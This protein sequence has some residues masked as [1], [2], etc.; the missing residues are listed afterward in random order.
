M[1]QSIRSPAGRPGVLDRFLAVA[2]DGV[3][4]K[5][6]R[7]LATLAVARG[8]HDEER[9]RATEL[10]TR[11]RDWTAAALGRLGTS[12]VLLPPGR[13]RSG[14]DAFQLLQALEP[15]EEELDALAADPP[16]R[17]L[18]GAAKA[19]A[20]T[21]TQIGPLPAG[22]LGSVRAPGIGTHLVEEISPTEEHLLEVGRHAGQAL[23]A[24]ASA[25]LGDAVAEA[26]QTVRAAAGPTG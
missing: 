7:S 18:I 12:P 26:E 17:R 1:T 4:P 22:G 10:L 25:G 24:W 11:V 13:V 14:E 3:S 9:E 21:G 20:R 8:S 5:Q 23:D 2:A 19:A 16:L 6:R 15:V